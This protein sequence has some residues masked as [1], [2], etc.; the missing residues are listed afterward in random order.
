MKKIGRPLTYTPATRVRLLGRP[1]HRI[2]SGS[3]REDVIN[4]LLIDGEATVEDLSAEV[5]EDVMKAVRGLLKAGWL[6]VVG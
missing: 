5:G 2:N 1:T 6:E 3:L 4:A